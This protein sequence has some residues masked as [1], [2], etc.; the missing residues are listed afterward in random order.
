MQLNLGYLKFSDAK[1]FLI[2]NRFLLPEYSSELL[3]PCL[4]EVMKICK[5]TDNPKYDRRNIS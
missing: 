4:P 2:Q 1:S 3:N 5:I